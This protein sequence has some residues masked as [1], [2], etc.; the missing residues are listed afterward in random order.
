[1]AVVIVVALVLYGPIFWVIRAAVRE[2]ILQAD[3]VRA[4]RKRSPERP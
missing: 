3:E 4:R 1:M 2:G